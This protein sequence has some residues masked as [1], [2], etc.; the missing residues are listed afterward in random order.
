[1]SIPIGKKIRVIR[2]ALEMGRGEFSEKTGINKATLIGVETR[3]REIMSG[4]LEAV[5]AAFP[6]YAAYLLTDEVGIKQENPE[7]GN[8]AKKLPKAK[9][10]S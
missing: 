5:A 4:I 1:M 10:A 8:L 2:E 9:K 6:E 7:V 3:D